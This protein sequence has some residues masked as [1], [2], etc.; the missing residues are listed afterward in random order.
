MKDS[1]LQFFLAT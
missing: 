1:N